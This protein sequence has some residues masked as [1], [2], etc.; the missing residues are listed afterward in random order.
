MGASV[1]C[2]LL[3]FNLRLPS[4]TRALIISHPHVESGRNYGFHQRRWQQRR[5]NKGRKRDNNGNKEG[6]G[7][8]SK[9]DGNGN[10]EAR[11]GTARGMA[12]ATKVAR[13]TAARGMATVTRVVDDKKSNGDGDKEGNGDQRR[14]HGQ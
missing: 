11:A 2:S 8:G 4:Y 13:A 7:K 1:H 9:M 12:T 10:K 5:K 3:I 6:K 14:H